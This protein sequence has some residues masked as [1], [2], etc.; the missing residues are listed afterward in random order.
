MPELYFVSDKCQEDKCLLHL[1][2]SF[3]AKKRMV[4]RN[5][6]GKKLQPFSTHRGWRGFHSL[7]GHFL[8]FSSYT[9][10]NHTYTIVYT[11]VHIYN[12]MKSP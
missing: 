12:S 3:G 5:L 11:I 4:L 9:Y 6:K 7:A 2:Q 1:E 8:L 10:T